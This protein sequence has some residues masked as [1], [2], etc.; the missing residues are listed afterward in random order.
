[1]LPLKQRSAKRTARCD[2]SSPQ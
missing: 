2:R 1:M